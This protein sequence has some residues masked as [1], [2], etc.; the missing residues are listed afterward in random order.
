M[1]TSSSS[2]AAVTD[3]CEEFDIEF[4]SFIGIVFVSPTA[5]RANAV[6]TLPE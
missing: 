2:I 4:I 1:R 6:A 5:L 3:A